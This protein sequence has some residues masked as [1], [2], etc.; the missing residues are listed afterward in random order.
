METE[1]ILLMKVRELRRLKVIEQAVERKL[2]QAKAAKLLGLSG[3]QI[4]RLVKRVRQEG[5]RGIVHRLRGRVSNRRHEAALKDRV[6]ELS[7]NRYEGFGPS[8]LA[9]KLREKEK[10]EVNRET[11]RQWM[12]SEGQWQ[13][14]RKS[15]SAYQWRERKECRGQMV[16]VDGSHHDWLEGRGPKLVLMGYIDDATSEVFGRFYDYEGTLPAMD[17]FYRYAKRYGLPHSVYMDRHSTYQGWERL[18]IDDELAGR[19]R[20]QSQFGRALEELGIELIAAQTPQA[21]GRVERLFRTLQDRLVKEMRLSGIRTKEEANQFLEKYLSLHNRRFAKPAKDEADLHHRPPK[22]L[23]QVLSIQAQH[24]LRNDNTIRHE[25]RFYQILGTW[26]MQ[27][28]KEVT[29]E[30]RLNGKFYITHRGKELQYRPL[31]EAPKPSVTKKQLCAVRKPAIPPPSHPY[32]KRSFE[33]Y[34]HRQQQ[35]GTLLNCTKGDISILR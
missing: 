34:L 20:T 26:P 5:A 35:K 16:Q 14:Q 21:K 8:L 4:K 30:Y 27:R 13:R 12:M 32:K 24:T 33:R 2:R 25:N 7:R 17:S 29:V 22:N 11:L 15:K 18:T 9:E 6:M 23:E 19:T 1:G 3:R 10:I 31:A 28:P